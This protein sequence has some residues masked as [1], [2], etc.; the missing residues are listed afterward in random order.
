MAENRKHQEFDEFDKLLGEIPSATS[1]KGP[2]PEN[3]YNNGRLTEGKVSTDVAKQSSLTG[4]PISDVRLPGDLCL[5]SALEDLNLENGP[6]PQVLNNA[7]LLGN[8]YPNNSRIRNLAVE[9][10]EENA[11][12]FQSRARAPSPCPEF[13]AFDVIEFEGQ[14]NNGVRLL[15][16]VHIPATKFPVNTM[17]A[18]K[19]YLVDSQ[20]L[21][22]YFLRQGGY[23]SHLIWRD[24]QDEQHPYESW[25]ENFWSQQHGDN[26]IN[27]QYVHFQGS[28]NFATGDMCQNRRQHQGTLISCH[29]K[30]YEQGPHLDHNGN[31]SPYR[32]ANLGV[33]SLDVCANYPKTRSGSHYEINGVGGL[34]HCSIARGNNFIS[35]L[36]EKGKVSSSGQHC[37]GLCN[38]MAG[39]C[40][41]GGVDSWFASPDGSNLKNFKYSS[42]S[43]KDLNVAE[44]TGIICLM[45]KDQH[46]CRLLQRKMSEGPKEVVD[47]IFFEVVDD[48]V[49]LMMDPFGNYLVQKLLEVCDEGQQTQILQVIT[50]IPSDLVRI[51][52]DMHGTRAIQKVIEMLKTREHKSMLVNS[53]KPGIVALMKN[54]NGNHVAQRC[55]Q[56]LGPDYSQ[57]LFEAAAA[58]C[59]ELAVER[60]G[61]C[62]LQKCLS[63]A[64]REQREPLIHE[65]IS[66]ALI[67]SQDPF[68][69]YVVQFI[70][71]LH[72]PEAAGKIIDQLE[73][74][75]VDLSMQKYSSNVVEKCLKHAGNELRIR[76]IREL[77]DHPRFD[78]IVQDPYGNYV[79]QAALSESE[80]V[81]KEAL[82]EAIE[83][84]A[85]GLRMSPYGK[86]VLSSSRVKKQPSWANINTTSIL[87]QT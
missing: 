51:S 71:D 73:G 43:P 49:E 13:P 58:N 4:A 55:L 72:V 84:H 30:E 33:P 78:Q 79:I 26:Q 18:Q 83:P 40:Q 23:D 27:P 53:L 8:G 80:G 24:P 62:V 87:R 64:D 25:N 45:A 42:G 46:G 68:G 66:N 7:F 28:N 41:L 52:C 82:V 2:C 17:T 31:E 29:C 12:P 36:R 15:P 37:C 59:V 57:F 32:R 76:I 14:M 3:F 70:F 6:T 34:R 20:S 11:Y 85:P 65:I 60:H 5:A 19:Q 44:V 61:C 48:I 10:C 22:P 86:K 54:M 75:Y 77:I 50:R 69:N 39:F 67:L 38:H 47:M 16:G 1:G 9:P 74:K 63:H 21:L 81:I 56:Y 35:H